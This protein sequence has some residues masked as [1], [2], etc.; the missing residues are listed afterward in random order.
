MGSVLL[1]FLA[2][3]VVGPIHRNVVWDYRIRA[4]MKHMCPL[5]QDKGF[6][7]GLDVG[8]GSGQIAALISNVC[9]NV[10][11]A[12]IDVL[13]RKDTSIDVTK[14]DGRKIPFDDKSFDFT[15]LIDVLHHA[16]DPML[17]LNECA[18]VSRGFVLI[19]DHM[20]ENWWD[21]ILLHFMDWFGNIADGVELRYNFFSEDKWME[22][23][24][25]SHLRAEEMVKPINM[26]SFPFSFIFSGRLHFLARLIHDKN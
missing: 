7:R 3:K 1:N 4:L 18:R 5:L 22:I 14:Y 24:S 13:V 2:K 19:K 23:F 11:I 16:E 25:R 26:Y 17:L 10:K 6:L 21:G 15:M 9:P 8:A 20:S 12:G